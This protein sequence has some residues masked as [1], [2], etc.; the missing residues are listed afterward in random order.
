MHSISSHLLAA[1]A[2]C[3]QQLAGFNV[4]IA[5]FSKLGVRKSTFYFSGYP[6][7]DATD[8]AR[9]GFIFIRPEGRVLC[10]KCSRPFSDH[11]F[12]DGTMGANIRIRFYCHVEVQ[13]SG[14]ETE[15]CIG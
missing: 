1:A 14:V 8:L 12:V 10:F 2:G 3:C 9:R 13:E 15:L 11:W 6:D 5:L 7:A 4:N